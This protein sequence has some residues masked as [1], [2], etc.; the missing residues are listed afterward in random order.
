MRSRHDP[1][2]GNPSASQPVTGWRRLAGAVLSLQFKATVLVVALTLAVTAAVSGYLLRSTIRLAR[3]QQ[4]EQLIQLAGVLARGAATL[5][6]GGDLDALQTFA[7]EAADGSPLIYT[8]FADTEGRELAVAEHGKGNILERQRRIIADRPVP[9]IPVYHWAQGTR[10]GSLS[11]T[12]PINERLKTERV[13]AT[14]AVRL[15]GYVHT[16]V[17]A[18][19]WHQ[20]LS[21]KLDLMIG[22]GILATAVAIPLGFLLVR[23]IVTPLEG[24]AAAMRRFSR[25]GLNVRS[26]VRRR[27]EIGR[28]AVAFNRMA[29]QHQQTHDRIVR[30]NTDLED[31]VAQ[32]TRQLRDLAARDPL[33]GLY[34]RRH[35]NEV[36]YR[37][38]S[39]ALRYDNDLSC[40]MVDLDDFK[41]VND[42]FGHQVGD[43]LLVLTATTISSQLRSADVPARFGG[44]EFIML[45]PQ[46]DLDQARV[47]GERIMDKYAED[48]AGSGP[49]LRTSMSVGIASLKSQQVQDA[50][51]LVRA[52][53][54]ALYQAKAAG[55]NCIEAAEVP[56]AR[57]AV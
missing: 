42:E 37:C 5:I 27:D 8:I 10:M 30:L 18:D 49:R 25:G 32:R 34:N 41:A 7:D 40:I 16:G 1:D 38:F 2:T 48:L 21:S 36:L 29:D 56:A 9:G 17:A 19:G 6:T 31:R 57:P 44:D 24:L 51:S 43:E 13:S 11:V 22:V 28:L 35:F 55:K 15:I 39:E 52:A 50:D 33:T 23:R 47:L 12:Y 53:D 46:T 54:R 3:E 14:Q 4:H 45:L 20:W 26:P